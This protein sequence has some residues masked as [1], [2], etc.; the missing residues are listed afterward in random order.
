MAPN[1]DL[2]T[3]YRPRNFSEVLGQDNIV[4]SVLNTLNTGTGR[5]FV[6][7]GPSGT[8]KTTLARCIAAHLGADPINIMEIDAATHSGVENVRELIDRLMYAPMGKS[9]Y[10]VVIIDEAHAMSKGAWQAFLKTIEE[11]PAGTFFAFCTT[12]ADRIPETIIQRC[13]VHRLKAL[14]PDILLDLVT[15]VCE[16]E[17]IKLAPDI[18]GYISR[19]S[20]G[21]PRRA[22]VAVSKC[23]G[24]TTLDQV[25]DLMSGMDL[26]TEAGD[27]IKAIQRAATW[28]HYVTALKAVDP[29][30]VEQMRIQILHYFTKVLIG[31]NDQQKAQQILS[32]LSAFG[33]PY[34]MG[35]ALPGFC[36][37]VG[38]VCFGLNPNQVPF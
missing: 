21:S 23:Q 36:I 6:F 18:L 29:A 9:P 17:Q 30:K 14:N 4:A 38:S 22:L 28:E 25:R 8:G 26:E 27:L 24:C 11:P 7:T 20:E 31:T 32:I 5:A 19:N 35:S 34:P 12:E 3:K 15:F 16:S 1:T 10:R 37:S 33:D 2:H 13:A